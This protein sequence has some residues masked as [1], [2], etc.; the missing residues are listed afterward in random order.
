MIH[1]SQ[2][3][4][5]RKFPAVEMAGFQATLSGRFYAAWTQYDKTE[6]DAK[7]HGRHG[8]EVDRGQTV[9]M[10]G[11]KCSLGLGGLFFRTQHVLRNRRFNN[12]VAQQGQF[13]LDAR[14]AP[15]GIFK[16]HTA[17]QVADFRVDFWSA[18]FS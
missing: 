10:V 4:L 12:I 14:R 6:Q 15:S 17:N 3:I 13:G 5:W 11:K 9:N 18:D 1:G 2:W 7:G 8:E 16:G